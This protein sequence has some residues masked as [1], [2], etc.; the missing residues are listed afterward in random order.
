PCSRAQ[1]HFEMDVVAAIRDLAE[2]QHRS[3]GVLANASHFGDRRIDVYVEMPCDSHVRRSDFERLPRTRD[4][5][6]R[7][8]EQHGDDRFASE[9][10]WRH[11]EY[12]LVEI[13]RDHAISLAVA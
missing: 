5:D 1:V 2:V 12:P 8:L 9:A 10:S 11:P 3:Q 13:D 7:Q 4:L 6:A